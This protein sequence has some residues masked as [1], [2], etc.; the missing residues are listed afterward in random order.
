LVLSWSDMFES[1]IIVLNQS[2][3]LIW[4]LYD[5]EFIGKY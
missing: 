2:N 1:K 5:K 3:R 4:V